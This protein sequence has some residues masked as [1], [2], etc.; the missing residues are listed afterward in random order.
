MSRYSEDKKRAAASELGKRHPRWTLY[1][2]A[3]VRAFAVGAA[4]IALGGLATWVARHV[5]LP[6]TLAVLVVAGLVVALIVWLS[7]RTPGVPRPPRGL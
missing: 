1:G 6:L 7:R 2:F 5:S 4:V 3:I